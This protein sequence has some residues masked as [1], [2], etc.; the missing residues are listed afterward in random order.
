MTGCVLV[1]F[2]ADE[3]DAAER[4]D[5]IVHLAAAFQSPTPGIEVLAFN[6]VTAKNYEQ[7]AT[8]F[9]AATSPD[10]VEEIMQ[11]LG[12]GSLAEEAPA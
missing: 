3:R 7:L 6:P 5:S 2:R 9:A 11:R 1:V 12:I 4:F 8:L 10:K